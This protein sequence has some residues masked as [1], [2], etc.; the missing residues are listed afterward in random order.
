M[1]CFVD[2]RTLIDEINSLKKL[3]YDVI[4]IP[5]DNNLYEAIDGHADIQLN[6]LIKKIRPN[7]K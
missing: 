1:I 4:K 7:Y 6:I 5:T 2:Y 3:N